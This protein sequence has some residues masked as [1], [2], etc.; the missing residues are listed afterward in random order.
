MVKKTVSSLIIDRS[1]SMM[2]IK[3]AMR[4]GINKNISKMQEL[5]FMEDQEVY[6]D[7]RMFNHQLKKFVTKT[8]ASE[9][10]PLNYFDYEVSGMT[11][12]FDAIGTTV[13]ALEKNYL[14]KEETHVNITVFTDG[15]ENSSRIY[16]FKKIRKLIAKINKREGWEF[17]LVG[18]DKETLAMANDLGLRKENSIY[19]DKEH[20]SASIDGVSMLMEKRANRMDYCTK[21]SFASFELPL[22]KED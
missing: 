2:S 19:T 17:I 16:S 9:V 12:L 4:E 5:D 22:D 8:R 15:Y 21:E 1:G 7:I 10:K 6:M 18:C 13:K 14:D 11:S 20:L 3:D